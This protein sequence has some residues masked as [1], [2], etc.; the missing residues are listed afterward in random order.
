MIMDLTYAQGLE[1]PYH[2]TYD[3]FR[4]EKLRPMLQNPLHHHNIQILPRETDW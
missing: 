1:P 2:W 4:E 3:N